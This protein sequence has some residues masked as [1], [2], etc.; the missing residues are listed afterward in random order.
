MKK[1]LFIALI[2]SAKFLVA[3]TIIYNQQEV[4]GTWSTKGSPYIVKGEAIVPSGKTLT[5]KAGVEVRFATGEN[6]EYG[7]KEF[8]L[9]FLRV[10]GKLVAKG[11]KGNMIRFTRIGKSGTWGN[12]VFVS[13]TSENVMKYCIIE[14]TYYVRGVSEGD[15]AT[16]ALSFLASTGLV[17]N[18][19]IAYNG[20]TG[21]NCKNGSKP[22]I[23]H[24]VVFKNEYGVESNSA[25]EPQLVNC[26]VWSNNNGFYTNGNSKPT[27]CY[28]LIQDAELPDTAIDEGGNIFKKNPMFYDPASGDFSLSASSVA[29]KKGKKGAN[30]GL[31]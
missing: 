9:G 5:I 18:C 20:W 8:D 16:G 26:I 6:R 21:I 7:E 12:I 11:K 4:S 3:E 29:Y 15:N 28:C 10:K 25:S 2:I 13:G 22:L 17:E 23:R 1:M 19:V 27:F 14:H 24:S 31:K 30:I